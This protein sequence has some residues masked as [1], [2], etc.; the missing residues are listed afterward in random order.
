[1]VALS[2]GDR[3]PADLRLLTVKGL[4]IEEAAL[5]GESV[6][7]EKGV[8]AVEEATSL[9]DRLD[10]AFAGTLVASG[11]GTGL[12]VATAGDSELGRISGLLQAAGSLET[13][14]TRALAKV[15]KTITIGI[16]VITCLLIAVGTWRSVGQG[17][18]LVDALRE[19]LIFAISLAVGAIPEGLPAIVTIALAVGVQRMARR[20]AIIRKLPGGGDARRHLG[21]LLRQDRDAHPQRDDGAGALDGRRGAR[22]RP[23]S[24]GAARG[25][26]GA[27]ARRW[28]RPRPARRLLDGGGALQRRHGRGRPAEAGR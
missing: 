12:V 25:A 27:E 24:A 10:L 21:H 3:V 2:S 26:S 20:R 9:G 18:P 8:A 28:R 5:T 22:A 6:P 15:G 1:M 19:M 11:T 13:P 4:R 7:A 17:V 23:A 16:L 14:L